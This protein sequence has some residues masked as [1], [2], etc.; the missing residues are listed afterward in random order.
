MEDVNSSIMQESDDVTLNFG[1]E[2][3]FDSQKKLKH[4]VA[5]FFHIFFRVLALLAYILCE[6][7]SSSFITNFVVIILFL[8]MDFWTV[9]NITGRLL[10]SLRWWNYVDDKG[11]SHWVF[12]SRKTTAGRQKVL[13]IESRI[14]WLSMVI[15]QMFWVVFIFSCIFRL[16]FKWFMVVAVGF[17][18]NGAN[19]YGY[20]RCKIGAKKKFT[21]VARNFFTTQFV[22]SM[23]SAASTTVPSSS[24]KTDSTKESKLT[25][26]P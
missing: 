8:C 5:V 18:M 9:K 3:E 14:F 21:T 24:A 19:L 13:S 25:T 17:L 23:F 4:P 1:E 16:N 15:S 10:V 22:R 26:L 20:I 7:F 11:D 6:Y 12:E 2:E